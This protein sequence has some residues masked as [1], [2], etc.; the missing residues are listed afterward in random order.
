MKIILLPG[1]DGTGRL[2]AKLTKNLPENIN[3]E[4][5]SYESLEGLFM[6]NKRQK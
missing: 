4:V 6:L 1:L 2:F 5:I 3:T